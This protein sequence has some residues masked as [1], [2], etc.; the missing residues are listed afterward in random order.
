MQL[1]HMWYLD[2]IMSIIR[3][4]IQGFKVGLYKTPKYLI[5]NEC[6]GLE[7][8]KKV[9]QL[10]WDFSHFELINLI[11]MSSLIYA[12]WSNFDFECLVEDMIYDLSSYCFDHDC[13]W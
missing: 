6:F 13:T 9:Y 10:T 12:I 7:V 2:Q 1:E 8:T 11:R 4:G 3:G 5:K